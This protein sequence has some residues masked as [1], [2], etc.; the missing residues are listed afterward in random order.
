MPLT[1]RSVRWIAATGLSISIAAVVLVVAV[2]TW[3]W[4]DR[5][6][7]FV[8]PAHWRTIER[9]IA[10]ECDWA[11]E[12]KNEH[13]LNLLDYEVSCLLRAQRPAFPG[14]Q[15]VTVT[16]LRISGAT[17]FLLQYE[18]LRIAYDEASEDRPE[19]YPTDYVFDVVD[20]G[21]RLMDAEAFDPPVGHETGVSLIPAPEDPAVDVVEVHG[22]GGIYRF[23]VD[24][25]GFVPRGSRGS[26]FRS[27]TS[28]VLRPVVASR[29]TQL[30]KTTDP[31]LS[32]WLNST[33]TG[34]LFRALD[35]MERSEENVSRLAVPL[36]THEIPSLRAYA[37]VVCARGP[38]TVGN[39]LA[40]LDDPE[41]MVRCTVVHALPELP[42]V[43]EHLKKA[44]ADPHPAVAGAASRRLY[45]TGDPETARVAL[46][47]LL[48]AGHTQYLNLER[49]AEPDS[50]T[51]ETLDAV[52]SWYRH[53]PESDMSPLL[54][55]KD[56]PAEVF[57]QRIPALTELFGKI[58]TRDL[59]E[60]S[61]LAEI[62][63]RV[64]DTRADVAILDAL[65]DPVRRE[66]VAE[67]ALWQLLQRGTPLSGD[68][69]RIT[70]M[71]EE[72][73]S[74]S[75]VEI[76]TAALADLLL[77]R[78]GAPDS[79]TRFVSRLRGR[80]D[81]PLFDVHA[82]RPWRYVQSEAV[83]GLARAALEDARQLAIPLDSVLADV[84]LEVLRST[85]AQLE[86]TYRQFLRDNQPHHQLA[87]ALARLGEAKL[88][89]LVAQ[90]LTFH[91]VRREN[92]ASAI[93][94]GFLER[95]Q[96]VRVPQVLEYLRKVIHWPSDSEHDW[97]EGMAEA[98]EGDSMGRSIHDVPVRDSDA[99]ESP[100]TMG[101]LSLDLLLDYRVAAAV[102][103]RRAGDKDVEATIRSAIAE[104]AEDWTDH[105]VW[106][107]FG[108]SALEE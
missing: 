22:C 67:T 32:T 107:R 62:L 101:F 63:V 94:L 68:A 60:I 36:L 38:G 52:L 59:G 31:R 74:S 10:L 80:S 17:R 34:E 45:Q 89:A 88:D 83:R 28:N 37:A 13:G 20:G 30:D 11:E 25:N 46:R 96:P 92:A 1:S 41:P 44:A 99:T 86:Q 47:A 93:L 84:R 54:E 90:E 3:L 55:V 97:E 82:I 50:R 77:M 71:L 103:L 87:R 15:R 40:L 42:A 61:S 21:G 98:M 65:R 24:E 91:E 29:R 104:H 108:G 102:L 48:R 75:T 51:L 4:V 76:E 69:A 9:L 53:A 7:L 39:L 66:L 5:M 14:A 2:A 6:R 43:T 23:S 78:R 72:I 26:D 18:R 49:L 105:P 57:K 35:A 100:I 58:Q 19:V 16:P 106:Q 85:A 64:D 73:A 8:C 56:Y 27:P 12:P 79:V 33:Q 81:P 95:G 70:A